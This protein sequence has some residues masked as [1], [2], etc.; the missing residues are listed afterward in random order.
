MLVTKTE[1]AKS[2][3]F[4]QPYVSYL[5]NKGYIIPVKDKIDP[6]QALAALAA[7]RK[8]GRRLFRKGTPETESSSLQTSKTAELST[9]LLKT[10]IKN[11]VERGKLLEVEAKVKTGQ[12]LDAQ[13][14]EKEA[15]QTAR[16][17]RDSL[18]NIPDRVSSLLASLSNSNEIY[19]ILT[20]EIRTALETLSE[21][22]EVS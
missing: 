20:Q 5:I 11:E 2:Q 10:R 4:T 18:Q 16:T 17:V 1:F 14:V 15:F 19:D 8:P 12:Y 21:K 7:I 6:E 3:G 13:T 9:V 22:L